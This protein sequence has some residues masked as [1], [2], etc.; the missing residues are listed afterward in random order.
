M[1]YLTIFKYCYEKAVNCPISSDQGQHVFF[2]LFCT[3]YSSLKL[4][5]SITHVIE[6]EGKEMD[7]E[8]QEGEGKRYHRIRTEIFERK[9]HSVDNVMRI[10]THVALLTSIK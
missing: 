6:S 5:C 8:G 4:V 1:K 10:F 7:R 3:S 9:V 2:K